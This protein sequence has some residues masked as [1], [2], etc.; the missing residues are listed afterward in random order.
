MFGDT[1]ES[2]NSSVEGQTLSGPDGLIDITSPVS[3]FDETTTSTNSNYITINRRTSENFLDD[4][5]EED[6]ENLDREYEDAEEETNDSQYHTAVDEPEHELYEEESG[7]FDDVLREDSV[8]ETKDDEESGEENDEEYD[9]ENDTN[10]ENTEI[11]LQEEDAELGN[12]SGIPVNEIESSESEDEDTLANGDDNHAEII[13]IGSDIPE[14]E[15]SWLQSR[16]TFDHIPVVLNLLN[17][18]FLLFPMNQEKCNIDCSH[19]VSLY[20][21]I[22]CQHLTIE[23]FFQFLRNNEDLSEVYKLTNDDEILLE[24]PELNGLEISEDNVYCKDITICDFIELFIRLNQGEKLTFNVSLKER[25]ISKFNHL[26][27]VARESQKRGLEEE[28]ESDSKRIKSDTT[29]VTGEV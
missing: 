10:Q 20:D 25:F 17:T 23:L 4:D 12:Q 3:G 2:M 8:E 26:V 9:D 24:I 22:E 27:E 29:S 18:E 28:E 19:L 21:N 6:I 1:N 5:S 16:Q 11:S 7:E 14:K 15:N 13:S